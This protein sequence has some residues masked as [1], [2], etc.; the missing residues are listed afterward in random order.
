MIIRVKRRR[1]KCEAELKTK[2]YYRRGILRI[3]PI[4][5]SP[6][7]FYDDGFVSILKYSR[8]RHMF[9]YQDRQGKM[10]WTDKVVHVRPEVNGHELYYTSFPLLIS[11][12]CQEG[13]RVMFRTKNGFA[14]L[15]KDI[16][17]TEEGDYHICSFGFF[18]DHIPKGYNFCLGYSD[19]N[20]ITNPSV[21]DKTDFKNTLY[22]VV[23]QYSDDV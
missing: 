16:K 6:L 10:G 17:K 14:H 7:G 8:D 12:N 21:I 23:N 3:I 22:N 2:Y 18:N 13:T 20:T 1:K 9:L 15:R 11:Q 4:A 5:N 19:N